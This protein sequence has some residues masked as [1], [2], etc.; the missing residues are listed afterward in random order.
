MNDHLNADYIHC[1]AHKLN[2]VFVQSSNKLSSAKVFFDTMQSLY[3][4]FYEPNSHENL[5]KVQKNLNI[6]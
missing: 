5:M 6:N 3:C 2:L 4:I 1:M